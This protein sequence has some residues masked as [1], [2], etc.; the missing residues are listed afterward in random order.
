MYLRI[1]CTLRISYIR[2][3]PISRFTFMYFINLYV[4]IFKLILV[5]TLKCFHVFVCANVQVPSSARFHVFLC[6]NVEAPSSAHSEVLS[7]ICLL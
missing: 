5:H 6:A 7:C 3:I 2:C 4:H 1:F